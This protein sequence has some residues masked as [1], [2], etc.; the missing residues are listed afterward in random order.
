MAWS[1]AAAEVIGAGAGAGA[2]CGVQVGFPH[3]NHSVSTKDRGIRCIVV[4][5]WV[6]QQTAGNSG[7][8]QKYRFSSLGKL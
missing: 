7:L 6:P 2:G 5:G 3:N 1:T 4:Q 8:F